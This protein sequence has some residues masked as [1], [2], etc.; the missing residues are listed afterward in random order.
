LN[1][2]VETP[3]GIEDEPVKRFW[4]DLEYI[5]YEDELSRIHNSG[6]LRVDDINSIKTTFPK[7]YR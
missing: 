3:K 5:Y 6:Y 7:L 2:I 1:C 4:N